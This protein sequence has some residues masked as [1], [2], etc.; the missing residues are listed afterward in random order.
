MNPCFLCLHD[1]HYNTRADGI[2]ADFQSE[3]EHKNV[4][5]AVLN[6]PFNLFT[7]VYIFNKAHTRL[8]CCLV[9]GITIINGEICVFLLTVIFFFFT[10]MLSDLFF[11]PN[12]N[13]FFTLTLPFIGFKWSF[14]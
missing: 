14:I 12:M 11:L 2:S 1:G 8:L 6:N 7:E 3:G 13:S 5:P 9:A 10:S 4:F